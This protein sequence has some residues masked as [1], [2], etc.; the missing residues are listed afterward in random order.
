MSPVMSPL[1]AGGASVGSEDEVTLA[2]IS[3]GFT[4]ET[5][6]TPIVIRAARL[7]TSNV[8]MSGCM[9]RSKDIIP[10]VFTVIPGS[11]SS[12]GGERWVVLGRSL[13]GCGSTDVSSCS[14]GVTTKELR[15]T[16]EALFLAS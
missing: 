5:T 2:R 12:I 11:C 3:V 9:V 14:C 4:W 8:R 1:S 10:G 13:E 6:T 7:P 16:A 15:T